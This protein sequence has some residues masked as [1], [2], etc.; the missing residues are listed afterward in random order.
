MIYELDSQSLRM[1]EELEGGENEDEDP[2]AVKRSS[3]EVILT[4]YI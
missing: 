3:F 2:F 4:I 1:D